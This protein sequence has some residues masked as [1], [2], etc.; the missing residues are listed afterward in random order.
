MTNKVLVSAF[1]LLFFL[2]VGEVIYYFFFVSKKTPIAANTIQ[3]GSTNIPNTTD[4][5]ANGIQNT[6]PTRNDANTAPSNS[7]NWTLNP[8]VLKGLENFQNGEIL[9]S[10]VLTNTYGG[11]IIKINTN[12]KDTYPTQSLAISSP[13]KYAFTLQDGQ[14]ETRDFII[15]ENVAKILKVVD[16]KG[17]TIQFS[18]LK[19][20]DLITI[21][22]V[23]DL[24][25]NMNENTLELTITKQ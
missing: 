21:K 22:E 4:N 6:N 25:K 9:H 8:L 1:I 7:Q 14:T 17:S 20:N 15:S 3:N 23:L 5:T 19:V 24:R 12:P 13:T 10:S 2:V 11:K 18:D 16:N